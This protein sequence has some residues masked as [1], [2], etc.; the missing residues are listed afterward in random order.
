MPKTDR[1]YTLKLEVEDS[2]RWLGIELEL[3]VNYEEWTTEYVASPHLYI[4]WDYVSYYVYDQ[5]GG[6]VDCGEGE[7]P[8]ALSMSEDRIESYLHE[9]VYK[10]N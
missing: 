5:D 1:R 2:P 10:G 6:E 3:V 8:Y 7:P 9:E 4:E